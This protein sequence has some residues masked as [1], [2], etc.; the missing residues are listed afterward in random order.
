MK[1]LQASLQ[2]KYSI[3][4]LLG[5]LILSFQDIIHPKQQII[6]DKLLKKIQESQPDVFDGIQFFDLFM[7]VPYFKSLGNNLVWVYF[8]I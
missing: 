2:L 7:I 4:F 1:K 5:P 6:A 8:I 3:L